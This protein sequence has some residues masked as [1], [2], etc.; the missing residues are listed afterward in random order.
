M[1]R[2]NLL[3]GVATDPSM[4]PGDAGSGCGPWEMDST[5]WI[6]V[7]LTPAL[8]IIGVIIGKIRSKSENYDAV[9]NFVS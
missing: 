2:F 9:H 6:L 8:F 1:S 3:A 4:C 5:G 7:L